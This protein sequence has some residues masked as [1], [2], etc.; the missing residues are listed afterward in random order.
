MAADIGPIDRWTARLARAGRITLN[1]HPDRVTRRGDSVAAGLLADGR[2]RSQWVT[3]VSAGSR[4]AIAG[5]ERQRF[6]REFFDGAYDQVDPSMHEH[7]VYGALDLLFDPHGGSPRFGSSYTI[8]RPHVRERTTLCLGDSH[9]GPPDV[10]TFDAPWSI[11]AG[12]AEQAAR[13]PTA[14]SRPRSGRAP[15]RPRR[16][17][18]V[19]PTEP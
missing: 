12:L 17:L 14:R 3:G 19:G 13:A 2:Y 6:E 1:F 8:L 16:E 5:G 9:V 4:S 15:R 11:L 7:P 18:S 10:G